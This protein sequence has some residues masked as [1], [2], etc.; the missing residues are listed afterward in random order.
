MSNGMQPVAGNWRLRLVWLLLASL[1]LLVSGRLIQLHLFER[2]FLQRQ[3]DV[4][5][6]RVETIP[7]NRGMITDRHGEPLAISSPVTT[8]W[9]NPRQLPDDLVVIRNLA[10]ALGENP[11]LFVRRLQ[12][13]ADRE[14]MYLRRQVTPDIA[15]SVLSQQI[16]GV[17]AMDEFRRYYPAGEVAAHL[18]G[19]TNVDERG[20]EGLELAW[21]HWLQASAGR[22]RVLKDLKGRTIRNLAVLQYPQPGQTLTLSLDMRLQYLAY[23]ELKAVVDQHQAV[24]G[25][26]ILLDARTGEVLAMVNQPAFNPNNRSQLDLARLRNRALVDLFEPGSVIKPLSVAVALQSGQFTADQKID[27]SPGVIRLAGQT[28]RDFRNYGQLT[29]GQIIAHSSNV[30]VARMILELPDEMLV[31]Y[32]DALGFGRATGTG[33][34]GEGSGVLPGGFGISRIKRATLSYGYG[35]SVT[36]G[37]L[38]QAYMVLADHGRLHPLSLLKVNDPITVQ[39]FDPEVVREVLEMMERVVQPGGTGTRAAIPGYRVAGKTG[40]VHKL[41]SEGYRSGDYIATFAGIAPVS[42]PR[43]VAVVMIDSPKGQ[44]YFGG[45]VA[46]PVFSRVVG[47]A[48]RIMD[49]PPDAPL[50]NGR[51]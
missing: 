31:N 3:G 10:Q 28:I 17:Y 29:P 18:V 51:P 36:L 15:E 46:A 45:E 6:L 33:F 44:E 16:P 13:F 42:D 20:Q 12:R 38:A 23:R 19:F 25:S 50:N 35:L 43:L 5:T 49:V 40:T 27:T 26:L 24:S 41:G 37:Q 32:Y 39:V 2:D 14:F 30:G 11:Q 34:P 1:L 22:K 9:A 4:R 21:D 8:L 7:A 47:H 48:L